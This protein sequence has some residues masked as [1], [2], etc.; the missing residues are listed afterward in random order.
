VESADVLFQLFSTRKPIIGTVHVL[1]L[2]GAPRYEGR[3]VAEIGDQAI[4][5]ALAYA[6]GGVDALIIENEGDIP[7]RKPGLVGPETVASLAV[8]A[9]RVGAEV[10]IP[11]GINCLANAVVQSIAIAKAVGATFV[12]ANQWANAYVANEGFVEGAAAEALR[13]R[14]HIRADDIRILADVHVKH[15]SH[16]IVADRSIEDLARDVAAFDADV[17]IATGTRTGDPPT[18]EEIHE[19]RKAGSSPL[20]IGS[21]LTAHTAREL[22]TKTEGA[23]VGS[24]LKH[25]GVWWNPVDTERVRVLMEVVNGLR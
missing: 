17:L 9:V 16:A 25:G 14:Q 10:E 2:P 20:L 24:S 12:R 23:V 8:V 6:D 4:G 15:G 19:I 3:P 5:D 13:F 18:L 21:G 7:F 11:V 1:A 22:L